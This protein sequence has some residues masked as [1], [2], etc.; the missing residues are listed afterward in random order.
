MIYI[1]TGYLESTG[2]QKTKLC[3][4][5]IY[6]FNSFIEH[7]THYSL[8]ISVF[9]LFFLI[10]RVYFDSFFLAFILSFAFTVIYVLTVIFVLELINK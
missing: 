3:E 8:F 5:F 2:S 9:F 4:A 6:L 10:R 1:Y 7:H